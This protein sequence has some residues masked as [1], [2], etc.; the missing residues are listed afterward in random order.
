ME[1]QVKT[2]KIFYCYDVEDEAFLTTL[3]K[4]LKRLKNPLQIITWWEGRIPGGAHRQREIDKQLRESDV[5]LL[6][7]SPDFLASDH[8]VMIQ[9]Q[10]LE[11]RKTDKSFSVVPIILRPVELDDNGTF[12]GLQQLPK[13]KL[14]ISRWEDEDEAWLGVQRGVVEVV[15]E[16]RSQPQQP[17]DVRD[18][19]LFIGFYPADGYRWDYDLRP[20][21]GLVELGNM[22]DAP[23]L[24]SEAVGTREL[25]QR[26]SIFKDKT[27]LRDFATL[28]PT[29]K[30]IQ[31]FA[32]YHGHLGDLTPIYYPNKVGQPDSILWAG[33]SLQFWFDE[34]E[35]MNILVTLWQMIQD[36]Q[37]EVL[38]EHIIWKL[39]PLGVL[40][41]WESRGRARGAVIASDKMSPELF[42]QWS[43]EEV[44]R[45]ALSYLCIQINKRLKGHVN[46]TLFPSQK[47]GQKA[48]MY[49]IPDSLLSAL[50]L[51][52]LMEVREHSIEPE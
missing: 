10:V 13:N 2:I 44:V 48:E 9:Q 3:E 32:N 33:E 20:A 14:P 16:L 50:Y 37:I 30:A 36:K 35:E 21:P 11:R 26:Y 40:F 8:C 45:P 17:S 39:D 47:V 38:K 51:L 24:V 18:G 46:P 49:M 7:V 4:H 34:I 52:L 5:V 12:D 19:F 23:W 22:P 15:D 41:I 27:V 1:K 31:Q 42:Y 29:A 43:W 25:S 28:S 6:L